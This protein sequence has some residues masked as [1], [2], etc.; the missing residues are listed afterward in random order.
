MKK[1]ILAL[2]FV[3]IITSTMVGCENDKDKINYD[4][5]NS[6]N[7]R[8]EQI[9]DCYSLN[10]AIKLDIFVDKK[11]QIVYI[12]NSEYH[13]GG[14]CPLFNKDGKPMSLKEYNQNK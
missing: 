4:N 14:I 6:T 10:G 11:T 5:N 13:E 7:N 8:F 1:K 12:L 2:I 9:N 3:G